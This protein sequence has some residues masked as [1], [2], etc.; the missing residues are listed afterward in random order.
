MMEKG[1]RTLIGTR[2][3][4]DRMRVTMGKVAVGEVTG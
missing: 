3:S 2:C 4:G 1:G